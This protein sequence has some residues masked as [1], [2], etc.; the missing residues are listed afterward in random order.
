MM[1]RYPAWKY[2][3]LAIVVLIGCIYALPNIYGE[4]PALQISGARQAEVGEALSVR[5]SQVLEGAGIAVKQ[6]EL[7]E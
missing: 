3:L 1:N 6:V 4:D 5:V 7:E 2:I